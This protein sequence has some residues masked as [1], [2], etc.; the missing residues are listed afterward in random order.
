LVI[1]SNSNNCNN[2]SNNR[3]LQRESR[4]GKRA[5]VAANERQQAD[6]PQVR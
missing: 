6:S 1:A 3:N 4:K 2:N 5:D